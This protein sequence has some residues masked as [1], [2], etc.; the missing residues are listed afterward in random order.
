MFYQIS[1]TI[2]D[3]IVISIIMLLCYCQCSVFFLLLL[4]IAEIVFICITVRLSAFN[5]QSKWKIRLHAEGM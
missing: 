2:T 3:I 1:L 5:N 4:F